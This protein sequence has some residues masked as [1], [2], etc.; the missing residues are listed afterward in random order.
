MVQSDFWSSVV[1]LTVPEFPLAILVR[2]PPASK[3]MR[4]M[5]T[6]YFKYSEAT[7]R[8]ELT[9]AHHGSARWCSVITGN[10]TSVT[11]GS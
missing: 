4:V 1:L 9:L 6:R 5:A 11:S 7:M 8:A 3:R 2:R 10:G